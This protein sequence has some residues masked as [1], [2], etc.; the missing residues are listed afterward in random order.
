MTE[1]TDIIKQSVLQCNSV[2]PGKGSTLLEA[3]SPKPC[4][5]ICDDYVGDCVCPVCG[6]TL[7]LIANRPEAWTN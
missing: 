6:G 7:E 4:R 5:L 1:Y 3:M 2:R